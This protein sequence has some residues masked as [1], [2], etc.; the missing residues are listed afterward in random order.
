M[1][2]G[3]FGR[4][5]APLKRCIQM[6]LSRAIVTAVEA[7]RMQVVQVN[8]LA[9][10]TKDG[11]EHFEPYGFTSHPHPGA[12]AAVGFLGGD[13]SHGIALVVADRRY[14]IAS[15]QP[16]EVAIFTDED[17][18]GGHRVVMR[19]GRVVEIACRDLHV[20]AENDIR[21]QAGGRIIE[22]SASH[23]VQTGDYEAV[24]R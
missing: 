6:M 17:Q 11:V 18:G 14:R 1:D 13:R 16:G 3:D 5:V 23:V 10:E 12:E 24:K 20:V 22:V 15:L 8:L 7:G 21:L 19:R 4:L 2:A 9:G